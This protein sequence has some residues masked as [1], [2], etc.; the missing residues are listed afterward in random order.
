LQY[1][2][3]EGLASNIS[4]HYNKE[5]SKRKKMDINPS[6]RY[7]FSNKHFNATLNTY[8][9]F[10][11]KYQ[12]VV[13]LKFGSTVFQFDNSNPIS[14]LDNTLATLNW[15]NNYMK[16]YEAKFLKFDYTKGFNKGIT[17]TTG[18]N[19]QHRLPLENTTNY[20]WKKV[21]GREFTANYPANVTSSN[22]YEHS[23]LSLSAEI[24]WKPGAKYI[25]FPDRKISIGSKY[26]TFSF[27]FKQGIKNVL[28]SD[29]DY[30]KWLFT[31]NDNLDFKLGGRLSYN[32]KAGGFAHASQ[33]FVPD[34][35]H[36]LGNQI[37]SASAYL[38]SFQLMPYFLYSNTAKLTTST[39]IE[40]HLNGLLSNKIPVFKKLNWFFVLG[41]NVFYN[42]DTKEGYYEAMFSVEN[43]FKVIRIDFVKSFQSAKNNDAFGIKFSSPFLG[44]R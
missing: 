44:G 17:I 8:Y 2:T 42:H 7:G 41:G 23:A 16:I 34:M 43:I 33:V 30:S 24:V 29:V 35:N 31:I 40:Y 10:G 12:D 18:I 6:I 13:N 28:G 39:H 21:E 14:V 25:E 27:G 32:L 20:Y 37:S 19:F 38:N 26:P 22:I 36:V 1:N 4:V 5:Y 9:S 15:T 11:K 3:V